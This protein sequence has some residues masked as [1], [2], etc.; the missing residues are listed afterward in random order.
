MAKMSP[1]SIDER[2]CRS[3]PTRAR[4][5]C[6]GVRRQRVRQSSRRGDECGCS[7]PP[8]SVWEMA[9]LTVADVDLDAARAPGPRQGRAGPAGSRSAAGRDCCAGPLSCVNGAA[10]G[11]EC[12]RRR[13]LWLGPKGCSPT[14]GSPR[15]STTRESGGI[16]GMHPHRFVTRSLIGGCR[17]VGP[18]V[19]FRR[20][21][22]GGHRRCSLA[23]APRRR[24][25]GPMR[26]KAL[27]TSRTG[28]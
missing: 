23:T 10:I 16:S 20:W 12:S 13:A 17:P 14:R 18:K 3:S 21:P 28:R 4:G 25:S 9:G 19:T 8:V 5:G 26:R 22:A 11:C 7:S 15:Y 2:R 27:S 24:R 1:P 6:C